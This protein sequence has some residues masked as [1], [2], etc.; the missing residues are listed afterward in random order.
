MSCPSRRASDYYEYRTRTRLNPTLPCAELS[1]PQPRRVEGWKARDFSACFSS[2][3]TDSQPDTSS[4]ESLPP[5]V[6]AV[7]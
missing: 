6:R 2:V 5:S 3:H 7:R 4:H 1:L